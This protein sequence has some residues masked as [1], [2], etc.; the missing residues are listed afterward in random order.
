[1]QCVVQNTLLFSFLFRAAFTILTN[2]K[3]A[4][5]SQNWQVVKYYLVSMTHV[6]LLCWK[7]LSDNITV[8]WLFVWRVPWVSLRDTNTCPTKTPVSG[9]KTFTKFPRLQL[10]QIGLTLQW[11]VVCGQSTRPPRHRANKWRGRDNPPQS[12]EG[13]M[14]PWWPSVGTLSITCLPKTVITRHKRR[15][16]FMTR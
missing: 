6:W 5:V 1:M 7:M 11:S 16:R 13:P 2:L 9:K 12:L 8:L 3:W 15:N 14:L 4:I 10:P